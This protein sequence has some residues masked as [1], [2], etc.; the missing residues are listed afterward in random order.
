M[1][2]L[3]CARARGRE[4]GGGEGM[5]IRHNAQRKYRPPS[6]S[7]CRKATNV[8]TYPTEPRPYFCAFVYHSK[9]YVHVCVCVSV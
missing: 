1:C 7:C 4:K 3:V 6:L 9:V 5:S 2:V 8:R